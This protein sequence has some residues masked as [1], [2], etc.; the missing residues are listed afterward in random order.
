MNHQT[1]SPTKRKVFLENPY[2]LETV[3][4]SLS[5]STDH[6]KELIFMDRLIA[7]LR[8]NPSADLPTLC[9]NILREQGILNLEKP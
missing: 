9:Y 6:D 7:N 8:L 3:F 4:E 5:I 2:D 1:K